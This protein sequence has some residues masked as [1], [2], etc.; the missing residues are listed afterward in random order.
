MV[1]RFVRGLHGSIYDLSYMIRKGSVNS[2]DTQL[3]F[4]R[5]NTMI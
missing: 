3:L 4:E 5:L 2:F 1:F